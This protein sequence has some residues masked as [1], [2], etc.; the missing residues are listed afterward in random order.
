MSMGNFG[1]GRNSVNSLDDAEKQL[2]AGSLCCRS[3]QTAEV[4]QLVK[5]FSG[6]ERVGCGSFGESRAV[7]ERRD[8]GAGQ[9]RVDRRSSTYARPGLGEQA[10]GGS[11]QLVSEAA[12][13]RPSGSSWFGRWSSPGQCGH[14]FTHGGV[15]IARRAVV[16]SPDVSGLWAGARGC[17]RCWGGCPC[18]GS[19]SSRSCGEDSHA[20]ISRRPVGRRHAPG[21][22]SGCPFRSSSA[23]WPAHTV[24]AGS[25]GAWCPVRRESSRGRGALLRGML[26]FGLAQQVARRSEEFARPRGRGDFLPRRPASLSQVSAWA[27]PHSARC[28]TSPIILRSRP[29]PCWRC[30]RSARCTFTGLPWMNGERGGPEPM[31]GL[32]R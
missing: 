24:G 5:L 11:A 23:A 21:P 7:E 14:S 17:C 26:N 31:S 6:Q 2:A 20:P 1:S 13:A 19:Q 3:K 12:G 18:R 28:T 8:H 4:E 27:G 30:A 9:E 29:S 15:D 10:T 25:P 16:T 22:G 32:L